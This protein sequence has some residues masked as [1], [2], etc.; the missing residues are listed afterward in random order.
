MRVV[1]I[2]PVQKNGAIEVK[3]VVGAVS[4]EAKL[5]FQRSLEESRVFTHVT[6]VSEVAPAQ[7]ASADR[8]IFE[9]TLR[10]E[11]S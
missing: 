6:P 9:L 2:D 10:Y 7:A 8:V 1:S 5:K 3:L 11:A 4:D